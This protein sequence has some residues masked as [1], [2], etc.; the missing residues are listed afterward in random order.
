[1]ARVLV[2]LA[3]GF[4]EI[5]TA[6]VVDVL[7][8]GG[9]EVHLGGVDGPGPARGSRG[10][11]FVPDGPLPTHDDFDLVVLPG[12]MGGTEGMAACEPL[13][14]LL[15]ARIA[16]DR[17]VAAICAA[18]LV[19]D[20]AGVLPE[21]AFTCYPGLEGRLS[22]GGRRDEPVVD[23]GI[24]TTSQGPG[25]AMAFALHLVERL[26]GRERRDEVARGLLMA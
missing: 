11:V 22:V 9:I 6:T 4:E 5:E 20:R 23:A 12:G 2:P 15:R 16:H 25:T 3:A 7:R 17:P 1:M 21:G 8:R 19:L 13:L 24:V 14:A 26:A 10:I 18:P